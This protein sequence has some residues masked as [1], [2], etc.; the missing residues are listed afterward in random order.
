MEMLVD[1]PVVFVHDGIVVANDAHLILTVR[2]V[3]AVV[4]AVGVVGV[5]ALNKAG[6]EILQSL[7]L[8]WSGAPGVL[9]GAEP[10][11]RPASAQDTGQLLCE[12]AVRSLSA[13][14]ALRAGVGGSTFTTA[15]RDLYL[16]LCPGLRSYSRV[17]L[18]VQD[19]QLFIKRTLE[20]RG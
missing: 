17:F 6:T 9:P 11:A 14:A 5:V 10:R 4:V 1:S 20:T 7:R 16:L 15:S 12:G 8:G 18:D 2:R 13:P 3:A 19:L